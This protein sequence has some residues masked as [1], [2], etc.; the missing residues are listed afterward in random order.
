KFL[1]VA[2]LNENELLVQSGGF[3]VKSNSTQ[4]QWM[5]WTLQLSSYLTHQHNG[6]TMESLALW[7]NTLLLCY[8]RLLSSQTK[9]DRRTCKQKFHSA[10]LVNL[11]GLQIVVLRLL[12]YS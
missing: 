3:I 5:N 1:T 4:L 8:P 10:C 6:S 2:E 7:M 12:P 9:R 11:C